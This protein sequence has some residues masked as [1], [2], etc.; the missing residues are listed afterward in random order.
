[1]IHEHEWQQW[2]QQSA[3]HA[4]TAAFLLLDVQTNLTM[5]EILQ[6]AFDKIKGNP[7]AEPY[8]LSG[9]SYFIQLQPHRVLIEELYGDDFA[10]PIA[11]S[12]DDFS[13]ALAYWHTQL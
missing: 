3:G 10:E 2:Q 6:A 1:M 7:D 4:A 8:S 12:L 9:N 13:D 5:L 11:I